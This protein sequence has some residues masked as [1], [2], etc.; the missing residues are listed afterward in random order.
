[1]LLKSYRVGALVGQSRQAQFYAALN[2]ETDTPVLMEEFFP[3]TVV[4][5]RP[6]DPRAVVQK[7]QHYEMACR[8]FLENTEDRG[9]ALS[10]AFAMNNTVYRIYTLSP[11]L[12][13]SEQAAA[14]IDTPIYF[15]DQQRQPLMTINALPIPPI[16][17][18]RRYR[19]PLKKTW[20]GWLVLILLL[21]L[22]VFLL[23]GIGQQP[24]EPGLPYATMDSTQEPTEEPTP[25]PVFEP[26][27]EPT[28]APS[29]KPTD[30]PTKEPTAKPT[31]IAT[32]EPA[33]EP[34]KAPSPKPTDNPTK[35][36]TA[37]P[38]KIAT[39][40]PADKPTNAPS[41][42]PTVKPTK[43]PTVKP[44]K[45]ATPE[46][47][48]EPTNAPSQKPTDK[49]TK[50]PTAKPTKIATPEPADEDSATT[51]ASGKDTSAQDNSSQEQV[52]VSGK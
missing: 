2:T 24:E 22:G 12:P 11:L 15:R 4:G 27:D 39:P 21:A 50:E 32:P 42:K 44:T 13:P 19:A 37:K 33:D 38:T 3:F 5:R 6:G 18:K 29:P 25:E 28:D 1:M 20:P 36:P 40:E 48:D 34:T 51:Q 35:E 8:L 46:P 14:L 26:A 47:A 31:K 49:P 16:P 23:T 52:E 43:E 45:I 30:K 10:D 17:R 9:L 7:K 41:P